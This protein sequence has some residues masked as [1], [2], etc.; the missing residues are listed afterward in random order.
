MAAHTGRDDGGREDAARLAA[1]HPGTRRNGQIV[2]VAR[3]APRSLRESLRPGLLA[4]LASALALLAV[5]LPARLLLGVPHLAELASDWL[6]LVIPL[7]LFDAAL[8]LLG[9]AARPLLFASALAL[10]LLLGALPGLWQA[11]RG[12]RLRGGLG[13]GLL[14]WLVVG[15]VLL[16]VFQVGPFGQHLSVG[17][18]RTALA[19]ALACLVQGLTLGLLTPLLTGPTVA[20][21]GAIAPARPA[22]R[23]F[24]VGSAA[25]LLGLALAAWLGRRNRDTEAQDS[26][27]RDEN[28]VMLGAQ[29]SPGTL[30]PL[31]TPNTAFYV[32][33][34]NPLEDPDLPPEV[35]SLRVTGLVEHPLELSYPELLAMPWVEQ[36]QTLECI[37]NEVGGELISTARWRGVPVRDVLARAGAAGW[38]VKL[39]VIC[40]DRYSTG[41]PWGIAQAPDTLLAYAMNGAPLP[42]E[43][44]GPVRLL[45][46]GRYGMKSAKW[47]VG[48]QPTQDNYL[49]YWELRGWT[50]DATVKTMARI[51]TPAPGARVGPGPVRVAGIAYAGRRGIKLV[52]CSADGGITWQ[53]ARL[54]EPALS[55]LTW[56]RWEAEFTPTSAA[57]TVLQV[58]A[59]DGQGIPQVTRSI[60]PL[61]YGAAGIHTVVVLNM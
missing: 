24:L 32:V 4:G 6:T 53:P 39:E 54:I 36:D 2:V 5:L 10:L 35:W 20:P 25:A 47:V 41:L 28:G 59:T 31:I 14:T 16:P 61:P 55:P 43:H 42:R 44:G 58:R 19:L 50:D 45:V 3:V 1:N 51:D 7:G 30:A 15:L 8:G 52:E 49:G 46:P 56:V 13:L 40:D 22:R 23:R 18:G 9:R 37:S 27:P 11:Q 17:A 57:R 34:K 26:L 33:S 29:R 12:W 38:A 48:L 60:P 21:G